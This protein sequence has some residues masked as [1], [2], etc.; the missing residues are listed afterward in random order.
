MAKR[1]G[2]NGRFASVPFIRLT[3]WR[4]FTS[5]SASFGVF[6]RSKKRAGFDMRVMLGCFWMLEFHGIRIC[7]PEKDISFT[8]SLRFPRLCICQCGSFFPAQLFLCRITYIQAF[9]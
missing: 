3:I 9:K 4:H 7:L 6:A 2:S 5:F 1:Q 8:L